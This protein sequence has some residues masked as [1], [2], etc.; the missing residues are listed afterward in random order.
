ME[1]VTDDLVFP[2]GMRWHD[3]SLWLS[4]IHRHQ[5]LRVFEDGHQ[6]VVVELGDRPSGL[7]FAPNGALY[8]VSLLDRLMLEVRDGV[9]RPFADLT[10]FS[11]KF[12]ND[13][14]TDG[15]GR[16]Y[17]G[18]RNVG[19]LGAP[20]DCV[21]LVDAEGRASVAADD[22][23]TPNGV[24]VSPGMST[25]VVAETHV[26]R[27]TAFD[28][29]IDGAL[30]NRRL[31]ADVDGSPD[32]ICLDEEGGVW[33]ALPQESAVVRILD[34]GEVTRHIHVPDLWPFTC[35]L[36]GRDRR[37][38]FVAAGRSTMANFAR[39][40]LDRHL[41]HTSESRGFILSTRVDVPGAGWP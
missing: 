13:M 32:G 16:S 8:V 33:A 15:A 24:V 25:L 37:T 6:E 27:L 28:V 22:L 1:T 9:A 14:I 41:D 31:F 39:L 19:E 10:A 4:D 34:G 30:E 23:V 40:G 20:T 11:D 36:G 18:C 17:V 3:G 12:A 35:V 38:L 29:G 21:V 5:V 2:E 7:G 26:N